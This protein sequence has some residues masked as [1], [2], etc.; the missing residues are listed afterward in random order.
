MKRPRHLST[1]GAACAEQALKR[2]CQ[3]AVPRAPSRFLG[4]TTVDE[5]THVVLDVVLPTVDAE[6]GGMRYLS[7]ADELSFADAVFPRATERVGARWFCSKDDYMLQCFEAGA[8]RLIMATIRDAP[9]ASGSEES[10]VAILAGNARSVFSGGS[11]RPLEVVDPGVLLTR[12]HPTPEVE[13]YDY[14]HATSEPS[15]RVLRVVRLVPLAI[16]LPI[17]WPGQ[18]NFVFPHLLRRGYA[19][20]AVCVLRE[21][22]WANTSADIAFAARWAITVND[23]NQPDASVIRRFLSGCRDIGML[24][25]DFA[26]P[27]ERGA[28]LSLVRRTAGIGR[29]G[30]EDWLWLA[31]LVSGAGADGTCG[32]AASVHDG[33]FERAC[34]TD[35]AGALAW[36][37][38]HVAVTSGCAIQCFQEALYR[39]R[40]STLEYLRGRWTRFSER[41]R[42]QTLVWFLTYAL[43]RRTPVWVIQWFFRP[44]TCGDAYTMECA[45]SMAPLFD[46]IVVACLADRRGPAV[47]EDLVLHGAITRS[48]LTGLSCPDRHPTTPDSGW[49]T[50]PRDI[51]PWSALVERDRLGM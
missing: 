33:L 2:L 43:R 38:T 19:D 10:W 41:K 36:A 32:D 48:A 14:V 42:E 16:G 23:A 5:L 18:K 35:D 47:L 8:R 17:P 44:D 7:H 27:E 15:D 12:A 25:A 37:E 13:I 1:S 24:Y 26:P 6:R 4:R 29:R 46:V 51:R 20:A 40:M 28:L 49:M 31:D 11:S 22:K 3:G 34:T 9:A 30:L 39:G 21:S 45:R 50:D